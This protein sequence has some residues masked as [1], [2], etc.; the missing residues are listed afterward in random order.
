MKSTPSNQT[1]PLKII[2]LS[3]FSR[4]K[5]QHHAAKDNDFYFVSSWAGLIARRLKKFKPNL[6]IEVW[7]TEDSFDKITE[8]IIFNIKGVIWPYKQLV[9]KNLLTLAMV[10]RLNE[11]NKNYYIILHYHDLFNLRFVILFRFLCPGIRVVLSHH[12]GVP[13]QNNTLKDHLIKFFYKIKYI[14]YITYLSPRAANYF[15]KIN[16]HPQLQFL[17]VGAEFD[18]RIPSDMLEARINLSLN[19]GTIYALYVGKF[20]RLKSVDL[21]LEAYHNLKHKYNFSIIFVG[22]SDDKEND[23][24]DEVRSSG[25][26]YF[27][28]QYGWEMPKFFNASNFYIHPA[29]H[30][31]FGGLDVSWIEALACNKPVLSTQLTYLDFDYSELGIH[32]NGKNELLEKT[33]WMINNNKSYTKCR[34]TSQMHLDGQTALMSKLFNIYMDIYG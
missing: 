15:Q 9:I 19:P 24:Y 29:F 13:P 4:N 21:I 12:G 32:L 26:P 2:H 34:E 1:R 8:K 16:N 17:P 11:L 28:V 27:G 7:R 23:L 25:C 6:D 3:N 31:S 5:P 33:E 22:G 30:P 18:T 20:Y 10:K 14:S